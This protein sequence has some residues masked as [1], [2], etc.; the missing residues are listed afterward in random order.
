MPRATSPGFAPAPDA[1]IAERLVLR[2]GNTA[3]RAAVL[4]RA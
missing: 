3:Q 4:E 2:F 1:S